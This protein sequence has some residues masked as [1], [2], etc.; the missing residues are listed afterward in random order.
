MEFIL[1][2]KLQMFTGI[3][4]Q[5]RAAYI[6]QL[7]ASLSYA[8]PSQKFSWDLCLIITGCEYFFAV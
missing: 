8:F 2:I 7:N 1:W 6:Y 3:R 4:L 5:I